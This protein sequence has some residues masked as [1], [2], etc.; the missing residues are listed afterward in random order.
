VSETSFYSCE[1]PALG[2]A[3]VIPKGREGL[4]ELTV[5]RN[6][7]VLFLSERPLAELAGAQVVLALRPWSR[8]TG[9]TVVQVRS[10]PPT[11]RPVRDSAAV[12]AADRPQ[13]ALAVLPLSPRAQLALY[14][15]SCTS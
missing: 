11:R 15:P 13:G 7:R 6:G 9:G 2:R 10:R 1:L 5:S 14:E 12:V 4:F 3:H 8:R